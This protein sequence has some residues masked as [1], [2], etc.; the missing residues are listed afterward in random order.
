MKSDQIK[1]ILYSICLHFCI[2]FILII[3]ISFN[4]ISF[5]KGTVAIAPAGKSYLIAAYGRGVAT[6][7]LRGRLLTLSQYF[8]KVFEQTS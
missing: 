2:I 4:I 1:S 6:G 3:D 7:L 8:A 5:E